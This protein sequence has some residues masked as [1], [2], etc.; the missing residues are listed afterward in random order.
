MY[1]FD[2]LSDTGLSIDDVGSDLPNKA[3]VEKEAKAVILELAR[4]R[5]CAGGSSY[6]LLNVRNEDGA[7]VCTGKVKVELTLIQSV[8]LDRDDGRRDLRR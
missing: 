5:D 7:S 2:V 8:V 4:D 6:V 1:Y 3:A